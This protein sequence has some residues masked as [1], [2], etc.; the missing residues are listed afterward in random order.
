[1]IVS[2]IWGCTIL[3]GAVTMVGFYGSLINKIHKINQ[4]IKT[5]EIYTEGTFEGEPKK[6][7]AKIQRRT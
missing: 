3:P 2:F 7:F 6:V 4:L 1:M 5:Q